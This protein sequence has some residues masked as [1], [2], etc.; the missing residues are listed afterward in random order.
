MREPSEDTP[1]FMQPMLQAWDRM[2]QREVLDAEGVRAHARALL[3]EQFGPGEGG[4]A[5]ARGGTGLLGEQTHY[6]GGFA[7]LL[8]LA[9]GTAVAARRVAG[10]R[11]RVVFKTE[12]AVYAFHLKEAP[13]EEVPVWVRVVVAMARLSLAPGEAVEVAVAS[14]VPPACLDAYLVA[15]AVAAARALHP[16]DEGGWLEGDVPAH[17]LDG[18]REQLEDCTATPFS[19]AYLLAATRG[20]PGSFLLVDTVTHESL[21]LN[22]PSADLLGW[23]LID[24]GSPTPRAPAFHR[25]R[26]VMAEEALAQLRAAGFD[27]DAGFRDV[28]HRSLTQALE[29]VDAALQPVVRHLVTE[30]RRVQRLVAAVR[31]E[32]W[33]M[34][35]ALLLMSHAS[36]RDVWGSTD[37]ALD[38]V[39]RQAEAFSIDGVYGACMTGRGGCVLVVGRPL[40]VPRALDRIATALEAS[41]GHP[42]RVLIL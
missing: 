19:I 13:G 5:Y 2:Q 41:L 22:G 25:K 11:S 37:T 29:T 8:P 16:H 35:G 4:V 21:A 10:S 17:W 14:T 38:D 26:K 42:P 20:E 18:V 36:L 6:A 39:V 40:A 24:L 12:E 33:Q 27:T 9:Q 30:N 34:F 1:P 31:R 32:D 28:E 15:L 7:V 3:D 23:G